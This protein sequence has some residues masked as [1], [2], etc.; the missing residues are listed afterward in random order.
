MS[1]ANRQQE[2]LTRSLSQAQSLEVGCLMLTESKLIY[3]I[4]GFFLFLWNMEANLIAEPLL[5]S[6]SRPIS[7]CERAILKLC[8]IYMC[9][10]MFLMKFSSVAPR[11]K[12]SLSLPSEQQ[13]I[14]SALHLQEEQAA[15]LKAEKIRVALEKIKEAQVKKVTCGSWLD[16][17]YLSFFF[18]FVL[19]CFLKNLLV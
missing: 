5:S 3:H 1:I 6:Y 7:F 17:K 12:S 11:R 13:F 10:I 2:R 14:W 8:F 9:N 16:L 19:F 18:F 15:K 4:A